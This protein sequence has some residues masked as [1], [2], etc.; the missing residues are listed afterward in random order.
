MRPTFLHALAGTAWAV[1]GCA[2]AG[3]T[4]AP[5][6]LVFTGGEVYT[7][8]ARQPR[9]SAVALR[10]DTIVYV[11]DSGGARA[12]VGPATRVIDLHGRMVLPGFTDS[13]LHP[14][15]GM[16][17]SRVR[18]HGIIDRAEVGRRIA[19]WA[20]E[21][22]KEPWVRGSGWEEGAFKPSGAPTRALLDSLVPDRPA[23]LSSSGGHTGWANSRALALA[24]VTRATRDPLNGRIGRDA[25][26]EPDGVLYEGAI[27]LVAGHL[28]PDTRADRAAG[29]RLFLQ[30]LREQGITAFVDASAEPQADSVFR[31]LARSGELTARATL[32]QW[33]DPARDDSLQV[34]AFV[35]RRAALPAGDLKATCVKIML[36]GVIEQHTGHLLAPYLDRPGDRGPLFVPR[37]RLQRLVTRLDSAGF[38]IHMHTIG[39]GA[40]REGLDA[41]EAAA[42]VNGARD[43]RPLLAH[44][45]LIDPDDIARLHALNVSAAMSPLWARGDDWNRAFAE[46]RLGPARS[47]WLYPHRTILDR[48][49]R[50]SWGTDWPV[51][52]IAPLD[53]IE[54]AVTRRYVG[55]HDPAGKPDSTWQPEERISLAEAIYGYTAAGAYAAY[56]EARRGTIEPGKLADLVVLDHDLFS[57]PP[58]R[59]HEVRVDYTVFGGR[60]VY[61]RR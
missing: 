16:G 57:V 55:G 4:P 58:L 18:L 26:G 20:A 12:F 51:T 7:V 40:V 13:H 37:P 54:T 56:D 25:R 33:Y 8:N 30:Q 34:A 45:Q 29:Y 2:G 23:F 61:E 28:P 22:S 15:G 35:A 36:D 49:G 48:G 53:G 5:A 31:E 46:P 43:R 38:Q 1:I 24:G 10:R 19:G 27:E 47:R 17:L 3:R 50:L 42:R 60:I 39:D 41:L 14:G 9:A 21:H 44:V 11:G 52:S 32:C 6:T 59:L